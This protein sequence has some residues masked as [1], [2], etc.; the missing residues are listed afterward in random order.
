MSSLSA[1]DRTEQEKIALSLLS[2]P[3][4]SIRTPH[5]RVDQ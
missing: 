2:L 3:S 4:V 5:V 1:N